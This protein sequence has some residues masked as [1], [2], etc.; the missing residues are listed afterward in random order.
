M[1]SREQQELTRSSQSELYVADYQ[2][3]NLLDCY[4]VLYAQLEQVTL[5]TEKEDSTG[6]GPKSQDDDAS[7]RA[8]QLDPVD[9][10]RYEKAQGDKVM[11]PCKYKLEAEDIGTLDIEWS[12]VAA[13]AKQEDTMI[14]L[15]NGDRIYDKY[16]GLKNRVYFISSD[17]K[18]LDASIEIINLKL[19]DT[20]T[21]QII[22]KKL[23]GIAIRKFTLSVFEKPAKTR[24]YVEGLQEIGNYL[25]LKCNSKE[26]TYPITYIWEKI[27]AEGRLPQSSVNYGDVSAVICAQRP[28]QTRPHGAR[29]LR[30]GPEMKLRQ[31]TALDDSRE[32]HQG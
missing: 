19:T 25:T 28:Q 12:L 23:P 6:A 31:D 11:F 32:T 26:G 9:Q 27:T 8:L 14:L 24:C 16:D 1:E 20:G 17:P 2:Y 3:M 10:T 13:D 21:Y 18:D 5:V 22:M 30:A 4:P 7:A 29:D 15:L